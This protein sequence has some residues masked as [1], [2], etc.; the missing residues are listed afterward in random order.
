MA[1]KLDPERIYASRRAA[2]FSILTGSGCP[3]DRAEAHVSAW[4]AYA[5]AEGRRA[6]HRG[7]LW[8]GAP[9]WIA[10]RRSGARKG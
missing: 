3:E 8:D 5:A 2:V 1:R 4:E 7:I 6:A 9:E 10:E